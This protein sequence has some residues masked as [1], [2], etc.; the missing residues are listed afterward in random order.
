MDSGASTVVVD[1][2]GTVADAD[3]AGDSKGSVTP[4]LLPTPA[5]AAASAAVV[6]RAAVVTTCWG[7]GAFR[8][9]LHVGLSNGCVA[10]FRHED[11]GESAGSGPTH[12]RLHSLR[13]PSLPAGALALVVLVVGC[14]G[15]WLCWLC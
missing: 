3:D 11:Y 4:L 7:L 9:C 13:A 10:S 12:L 6:P 8:N 14:V 5:T 1:G 15:C 2:G